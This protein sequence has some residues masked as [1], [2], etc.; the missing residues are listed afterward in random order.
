[1][2]SSISYLDFRLSLIVNFAP[3]NEF[4]VHITP[5]PTHPK[6]SSHRIK[7][8]HNI[9]NHNDFNQILIFNFSQI[10][11]TTWKMQMDML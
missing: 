2:G 7:Y 8:G 1:M 5:F 3:E 10:E 4:K 9:L 11:P 6:H